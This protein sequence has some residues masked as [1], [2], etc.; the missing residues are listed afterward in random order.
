[1]I[2]IKANIARCF[3]FVKESTATF[4]VPVLAAAASIQGFNTAIG[5]AF[6]IYDIERNS[7]L[8]QGLW[9]IEL[10]AMIFFIACAL[11]LASLVGIWRP[12]RKFWPEISALFFLYIITTNFSSFESL[13]SLKDHFGTAFGWFGSSAFNDSI[14]YFLFSYF[15][16]SSIFYLVMKFTVSGGFS[17]KTSAWFKERQKLWM[18][19]LAMTASWTFTTVRVPDSIELVINDWNKISLVPQWPTAFSPPQSIGSTQTSYDGFT[20]PGNFVNWL[21]ESSYKDS[22]NLQIFDNKALANFL[23]V[24]ASGELMAVQQ[25]S[26]ST[27]HLD[28]V[29][30]EF[31]VSAAKFIN[32]LR[33]ENLNCKVQ[34]RLSRGPLVSETSQKIKGKSVV[35]I[36]PFLTPEVLIFPDGTKAKNYDGDTITNLWVFE[37]SPQ[38]EI[39][40][41][42]NG[43]E[44]SVRFY[45]DS[46]ITLSVA[47][48][49]LAIVTKQGCSTA[50]RRSLGLAPSDAFDD[51]QVTLWMFAD[52]IKKGTLAFSGN[53]EFIY[54]G[55]QWPKALGGAIGRVKSS[56]IDG[57]L[58][59]NGVPQ[60]I[61]KGQEITLSNVIPTYTAGDGYASFHSRSSD[62]TLAGH[63]ISKKLIVFLSWEY[64]TAIASI[65]LALFGWLQFSHWWS[66]KEKT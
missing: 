51:S 43:D 55:K 38:N 63:F 56:E 60:Q 66:N 24:A 19:I 65:A 61:T 33:V 16:P 40:Y 58:T 50:L 15:L 10:V 25:P 28:L 64:W 52:P 5:S 48:A 45:H 31:G 53:S 13:Y 6:N 34:L 3:D 23:K 2:D 41:D 20:L 21:G 62:G 47:P 26:K 11:I 49:Y 14:N 44:K 54:A 7:R 8:A 27:K 42:F 30:L 57:R 29:G 37:K 35:G 32:A 9:P 39:F 36:M 46:D 1:M 59:V 4:F 17:E 12:A 18:L 22:I